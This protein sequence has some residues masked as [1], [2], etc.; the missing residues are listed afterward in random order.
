ME[1][2]ERYSQKHC[3]YTADYHLC[4]QEVFGLEERTSIQWN[5]YGE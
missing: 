5:F 2:S 4:I 1:E 3:I